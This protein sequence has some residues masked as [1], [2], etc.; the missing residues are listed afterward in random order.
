MEG[1]EGFE[2]DEA[3]AKTGDNRPMVETRDLEEWEEAAIAD[4]RKAI[5][6]IGSRRYGGAIRSAL[7]SCREIAGE[8][9]LH[10][11]TP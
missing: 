5:N 6:L 11:P 1:I 9:G 3:I 8:K 2:V 7:D 4:L 10:I